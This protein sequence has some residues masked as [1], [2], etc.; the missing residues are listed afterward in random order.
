MAAGELWVPTSG[1][2]LRFRDHNNVIRTIPA[3]GASLVSGSLDVLGTET[4]GAIGFRASNSRLYWNTNTTS[5]GSRIIAW[6]EPDA[7][8]G[9]GTAWGPVG[10]IAVVKDIIGDYALGVVSR[11]SPFQ[12]ILYYGS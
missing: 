5:G 6:R 11:V 9:G 4:P 1:T 7:V 8:L 3:S 10:A 12:V 2:S